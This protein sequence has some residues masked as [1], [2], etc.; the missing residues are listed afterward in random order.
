MSPNH[1]T[2]YLRGI[3]K[4]ED[5]SSRSPLVAHVV[6]SAPVMLH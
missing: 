1:T 2:K 4:I 5:R 3:L 6:G